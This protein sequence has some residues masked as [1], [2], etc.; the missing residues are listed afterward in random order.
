MTGTAEDGVPVEA[1]AIGALAPVRAR[2]EPGM[3]SQSTVVPTMTSATSAIVP[4]PFGH[5]L[6]RGLCL[7]R[8]MSASHAVLSTPPEP[9]GPIGSVR[10]GDT[11][12]AGGLQKSPES[13][14]RFV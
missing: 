7:L 5:G 3:V 14:R 8:S 2:S 9:G 13:L 1:A 12:A 11:S 6:R 4:L 10:T